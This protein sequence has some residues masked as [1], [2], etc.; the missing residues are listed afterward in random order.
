MAA[1]SW[2]RAGPQPVPALRL[3]QMLGGEKCVKQGGFCWCKRSAGFIAGSWLQQ[4]GLGVAQ[5][6]GVW[7]SLMPSTKKRAVPLPA[8]HLKT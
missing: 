1:A 3:L 5:G 6:D 2:V 7:V 4:G 8:K